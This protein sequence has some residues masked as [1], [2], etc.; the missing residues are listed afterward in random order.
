MWLL[1]VTVG[2][3]V[4][5]VIVTWGDFRELT[6]LQITGVWLLVAGVAIQI[7]LEFVELDAD[8]IDTIGY[9]LLMVSYA[10]ILAFCLSNVSIR[11]FGVI[12]VGLG[13]NALVIGLNQGMPTVAIGNNARGER[14]EKPV[15]HTVKHRPQ[16]DDDLL[17]FLDD[18]ILFPEPLDTVVSFGDLD[19]GRR[20]LRARV[21]RHATPSTTRRVEHGAIEEL[22]ARCEHATLLEHTLERADDTPV[23]D[24]Q[25]PG[26]ERFHGPDRVLVV[27][28][29]QLVEG[30]RDL[31]HLPSQRTA[32]TCTRSRNT[33]EHRLGRH[34]VTRR[35]ERLARTEHRRPG[36]GDRD[37]VE[38]GA[39]SRGIETDS[40]QVVQQRSR[41]EL[42]DLGPRH[43]EL[44][45]H[46][47]RELRDPLHVTGSDETGDLGCGPECV[48][49]LA[50]VAAGRGEKLEA[51]TTQQAAGSRTAAA[52]RARGSPRRR[53]RRTR[54]P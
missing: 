11:G 17:G 6:R 24:V 3:A 49:R 14:V 22:A 1:V 52:P 8:Q 37:R 10:L 54:R 7:A 34:D 2:A 45:A 26:V 41:L 27:A 43:P 53:S 9:G 19:H 32:G 30:A 5:L 36:F 21:L 29:G 46:R 31:E 13:L 38:L 51:S 18:R 48:H 25:G 23:V 15:E 50:K 4:L 40:T 35:C 20:H 33:M 28:L 12:A 42:L 44:A 47:G 39:R 16:S